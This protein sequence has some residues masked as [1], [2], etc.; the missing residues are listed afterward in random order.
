MEKCLKNLLE[1]KELIDIILCVILMHMKNNPP[2]HD[3]GSTSGG[4]LIPLNSAT[5][6]LV[7]LSAT[8]NF[9]GCW[10]KY[11][12]PDILKRCNIYFVAMK[13]CFI[14]SRLNFLN[15]LFLSKNTNHYYMQLEVVGA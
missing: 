15:H 1:M 12:E 8:I 5:E 3:D 13:N 14:K 10:L 7:S 2:K 9:I 6:S 4:Y 11:F